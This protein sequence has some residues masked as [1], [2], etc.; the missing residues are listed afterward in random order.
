VKG[1]GDFAE[2][3]DVLRD[4]VFSDREFFLAKVGYVLSVSTS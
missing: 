4:A 3:G 2:E 1:G